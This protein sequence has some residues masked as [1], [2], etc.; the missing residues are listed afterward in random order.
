HYRTS[1][2]EQAKKELVYEKS[3]AVPDV[4]LSANYDRGG[5]IYPDFWGVGIAMDLPFFNA[6]KGNIRKAEIAVEQE[7]VN[8]QQHV[9]EIQ[10]TV[11]ATYQSLMETSQFLKEIDKDY[12]ADLDRG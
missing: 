9:Q 12:T 11:Y 3:L 4:E 7:A 10:N 6:N 2:K 8:Q 1:A 5:G